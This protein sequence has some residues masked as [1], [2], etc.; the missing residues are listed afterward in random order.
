MTRCLPC[1]AAP[2]LVVALAAHALPAMAKERPKGNAG[3]V[4][5]L[6][7]GVRTGDWKASPLN[8]EAEFYYRIAIVSFDLAMDFNIE[9]WV[10]GETV[11]FFFIR[12]GLRIEIPRILY[13][14]VAGQLEFLSDFNWGFLAGVGRDIIRRSVIHFFV[15]VDVSVTQEAG[16][17]DRAP[18]ELRLGLGFPF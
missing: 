13:F 9:S 2:I 16:W 4:F 7:Q 15:E 3:I 11:D 10:G 18:L 1:V 6:A 12:P 17:F 14:R 5:S 8:A